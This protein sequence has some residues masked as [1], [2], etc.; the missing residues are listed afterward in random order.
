MILDLQRFIA[1]EQS[2]WDELEAMLDRIAS[3]PG[4][5]PSLTEAQRLHYLYRRA[6][7]DLSRVTT[8]AAEP[9]MR[10]YL[11][12]LVGRAY[13]EIHSTRGASRRFKPATWLLVTF[14]RAFRRQL[15]AFW[16]ALGITLAGGAV[17]GLLAATDVRAKSALLPFPHL[18]QTPSER[19]A[20]EERR[21]RDRLKGNKAT[22]AAFLMTHNTKVSISTLALG[23]TWGIGTIIMLF[24]NG[25][26]LG[27]VCLEYILGGEIAF[28]IGW[29]LPHGSIE[30][31][32]ILLAGQAGLVLARAMIGWGTR[33]PMRE[34][35]EKIGP[36]LVTL[37]GGVAIMLIWAGIVESFLS[38]YHEPVMP[39]AVKILLGSIELTALIVFLARSGRS[40]REPNSG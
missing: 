28:L 1:D 23:M 13:T 4:W 35:L 24:Y 16:L 39:Y 37:I 9:E 10:G 31:P 18:R 6:S 40:G 38:Q 3:I 27:F 17:G 22:F 20:Q 36:D 8:F 19:V 34:R 25:I 30:I 5:R 2:F 11:E 12:G 26:I 21:T 7:A 14:P 29:L 33:V 32:A 15:G